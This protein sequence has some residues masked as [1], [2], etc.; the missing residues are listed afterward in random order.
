MAAYSF[1]V[2]CVSGIEIVAFKTTAK[3]L[4]RPL[5]TAFY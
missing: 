3:I 4:N 2:F 5:M 1:A